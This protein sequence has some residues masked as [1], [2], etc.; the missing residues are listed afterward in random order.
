MDDIFY[1]FL[2]VPFLLH[3]KP[4]MQTSD[5]IPPN[6][7]SI[8][9]IWNFQDTQL[10]DIFKYNIFAIVP[11]TKILFCSRCTVSSMINGLRLALLSYSKCLGIVLGDL[12]RGELC[13][14]TFI[15]NLSIS[16]KIICK[17]QLGITLFFAFIIVVCPQLILHPII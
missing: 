9:F 17:F 12:V 5:V 8:T 14:T 4:N 13:V 10:D 2:V 1:T 7:G 6:P 11:S 15:K 3:R 16:F